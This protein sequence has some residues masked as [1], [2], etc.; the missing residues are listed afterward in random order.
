MLSAQPIHG[1]CS[2]GVTDCVGP[3][4]LE[5]V[6]GPDAVALVALP[7]SFPRPQQ[8]HQYHVCDRC[9]LSGACCVWHTG[10]LGTHN[11]GCVFVAICAGVRSQWLHMPCQVAGL[12][13]SQLA[14]Q[15][16]PVLGAIV[17]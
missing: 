4:R 16:G 15:H 17:C 6:I 9:L 5:R 11:M 2:S 10:P 7:P 14:K 13:I 3:P 1:M 8:V 12:Q